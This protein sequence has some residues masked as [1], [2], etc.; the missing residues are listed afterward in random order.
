M[1]ELPH[2]RTGGGEGLAGDQEALLRQLRHQVD[3]PL[4]L[5]AQHRGLVHAHVLEEE[6]AC[7]N[8]SSCKIKQPN[9]NIIHFNCTQSGGII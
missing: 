3:E 9:T 5:L 1:L 6:L 2:G 7:N 8:N 4:V